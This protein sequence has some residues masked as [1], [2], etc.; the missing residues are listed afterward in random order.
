MRI[1]DASGPCWMDGRPV[2]AAA[3]GLP[4]DDPAAQCGLGLFET[5]AVRDGAVLELDEHLDR[6]R[7]GGAALR[8][9]MPPGPVL[10]AHVL[11][12]LP[13]A[14][15]CGWIKLLVTGAGRSIVSRGA[16][17]PAE[18]GRPAAAVLLPWR[19]NPKDPLTGLK[20]LNYAGNRL[21]I[22]EAR[23]R[24]A[25][26]GLWLNVRG[27]LAEGCTSNL[28]IVRGR[29][30][31]TPALGEGVLP[32]VTRG[33]VLAAA[34]ELGIPAFE[35][36]VRLE[37]LERAGEAFLTSSLR[38]VRPLVRFQGRPL[39]SGLPGPVTRRLAIAVAARRRGT[40]EGSTGSDGGA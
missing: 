27:R 36:R 11:G 22:D 15:P 1:P 17:D 12:A 3:A 4:L 32:G 10:R 13:G 7:A 26:E 30:L 21:G 31:M 33:L 24:G 18:E 39:G 6:L 23:R 34:R 5:M 14:P 2:A 35:V 38:G 20:T 8:L 28:F 40:R 16:M 19:R 25:D 37:R 29:G 9:T